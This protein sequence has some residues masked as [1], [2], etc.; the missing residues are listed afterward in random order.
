MRLKLT[1]NLK[2]FQDR[3]A[4]KRKNVDE[5]FLNRGGETGSIMRDPL[6]R[7]VKVKS[8]TGLRERKDAGN[9]EKRR[10][11]LELGLCSQRSWREVRKAA[12]TV[13]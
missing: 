13:S 9:K 10:P 6:H 7:R 2:S 12:E 3:M 8:W 1:L 5:N 4:L 11:E